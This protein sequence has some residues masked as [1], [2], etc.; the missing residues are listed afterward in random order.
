MENNRQVIVNRDD[1]NR[2]V[3]RATGR[4]QSSGLR[5]VQDRQSSSQCSPIIGHLW[6]IT[7]R[8][9]S[10]EAKDLPAVARIAKEETDQ[11]ARACPPEL[12]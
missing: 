10:A 4:P 6:D 11:A 5:P 9:E 8:R 2:Q 7:A 12:G 3:P 1:L